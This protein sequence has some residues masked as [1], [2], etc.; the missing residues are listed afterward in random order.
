MVEGE[1]CSFASIVHVVI[2]V[3]LCVDVRYV[4]STTII[5][6]QCFQLCIEAAN[7]MYIY[8][9]FSLESLTKSVTELRFVSFILCR[10][11]HSLPYDSS[12]L[13]LIISS[14]FS[15]N[16]QSLVIAHRNTIIVHHIFPNISRGI[17]S[18]DI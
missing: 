14:I 5:S 15:L 1:I 2:N 18:L 3:P 10:Y 9:K 8:R 6:L 11:L 16:L 12:A 13:P 4:P 17:N 7:V